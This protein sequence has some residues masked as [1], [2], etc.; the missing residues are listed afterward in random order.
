MSVWFALVGK[1]L[2][3]SSNVSVK[4]P[5]SPQTVGTAAA[6]LVV[7][8]LE[9]VLEVS[10]EDP[11]IC[12]V[13]V[14]ST[15]DEVLANVVTAPAIDVEDEVVIAAGEELLSV[16][17]MKVELLLS[18]AE[19]KETA[20]VLIEGSL[21][22]AACVAELCENGAGVL[23]YVAARE[24]LSDCAEVPALVGTMTLY[25]LE[26]DTAEPLND[27]EPVKAEAAFDELA[28]A[29]LVGTMAAELEEGTVV[30]PLVLFAGPDGPAAERLLVLTEEL[31]TA[32]DTE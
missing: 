25:A 4:L 32:S 20:V 29:L 30:M 8:V 26:V 13:D 11:D 5:C 7:D 14:L 12:C 15:T 27:A 28:C 19:L 1:K 6:E 10:G 21:P 23:L 16:T 24:L 31:D 3:R 22:V 9:S 18:L 2:G 17:V